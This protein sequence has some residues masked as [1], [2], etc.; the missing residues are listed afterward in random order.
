MRLKKKLVAFMMTAT[1]IVGMAPAAFAGTFSD[2]PATAS[3]ADAVN[4]LAALGMLSGIGDGKYD[5]ESAYTRAQFAALVTKLLGVESAAKA[6][7][8]TTNF[9][10]V[11]ADHWGSGYV[12][13]ASAM[14][15]IKGNGDGTFSPD[16][17]VTH[18]QALTM[19]VRALGY[20]PM[21]KGTWP[22]NV[23]VKAAELGLTNGVNV[24]SNLPA[25]RGEVAMF[26]N[27]GVEVPM[28]IQ[29][30]AGDQ[31]KFV[32]SGTEN[33]DKRTLLNAGVT[34]TE[35][36]GIVIE[37]GATP[38]STLDDNQVTVDV[39]KKNGKDCTLN[40]TTTYKVAAGVD[41]VGLLGHD[42]KAPVRTVSGKETI[43]GA[44]S[45]NAGDMISGYLYDINEGA[46][47]GGSD[48]IILRTDLDKATTAKTYSTA[49]AG[50]D[51]WNDNVLQSDVAGIVY[52]QDGTNNRNVRA[53][54]VRDSSG[55]VFRAIINNWSSSKLFS[56]LNTTGDRL[57][58]QDGGSTSVKDKTVT[59]IRNGKLAAA[60]DLQKNDVVYVLNDGDDYVLYAVANQATGKITSATSTTPR[61]LTVAGTKYEAGADVQYSKDNGENLDA[62]YTDLVGQDATLLLD[63]NGRVRA[64]ISSKGS[65]TAADNY[66]L[67]ASLWQ[68]GTADKVVKVRFWNNGATK[69]TYDVTDTVKLIEFNDGVDTDTL[70]AS[71]LEGA[72]GA[73]QVADKLVLVQGAGDG[74]YSVSGSVYTLNT[75]QLITYKLTSDGKLSEITMTGI[76]ETNGATDK[77][78]FDEDNSRISNTNPADGTA[79]VNSSTLFFDADD[80]S[81]VK[82][83]TWDGIKKSTD[84]TIGGRIL[85][86]DG[87]AKVVLISAY[88]GGSVTEGAK[89]FVVK[90]AAQLTGDDTYT[91]EVVND[92]GETKSYTAKSGDWDVA[93]G[94]SNLALGDVVTIDQASKIKVTRYNADDTD[95]VVK[96]DT[97]LLWLV[98]DTDNNHI[99]SGGDTEYYAVTD[100]LVYDARND[101]VAKAAFADISVGS[102]VK[103]Y[104]KSSSND[105]EVVVITD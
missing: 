103:V 96:R 40:C 31:V 34:S 28:M 95:E 43:V 67:L 79:T 93:V 105:I 97:G 72:D 73:K 98:L 27:N 102:N 55:R 68:E 52:H 30:G 33:T 58:W 12:N 4:R 74:Q 37:T 101:T 64:A 39:K 88:N 23:L 91:L 17:N 56:E 94:L 47:A 8:G 66:G 7:A 5:P 92:A 11:A 2:V 100:V 19:L 51:F 1:M 24:V 14:G 45:T 32:V 71:V 29:V 3:Y 49:T 41:M 6:S 36:E 57:F 82:T 59:V 44:T 46:G 83:R 81:S 53:S 104:M 80:N 63:A 9:S 77:L 84:N 62:A 20:E 99:K 21:L 61:K 48:Q 22:A 38:G 10:D 86:K 16:A 85:R 42:V 13:V 75:F 50:Y 60:K 90:D 25:T 89:K 70:S 78:T 35:I 18:A 69:V 15:I 26:A 87:V 76:A 54:V 65:T